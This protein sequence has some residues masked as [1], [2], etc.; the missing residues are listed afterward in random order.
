M[1]LALWLATTVG[2]SCPS[3]PTAHDSQSC[4]ALPICALGGGQ[5]D[6]GIH[7][8]LMASCLVKL[9]LDFDG[10]HTSRRRQLGSPTEDLR[11][12]RSRGPHRILGGRC[13]V[14]H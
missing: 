2:K 9:K 13:V 3:P 1:D 10:N 8:F 6:L 5:S 7:G 11:S 4:A 14:Q 12:E